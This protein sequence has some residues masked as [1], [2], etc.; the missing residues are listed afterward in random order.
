MIHYSLTYAAYD[1]HEIGTGSF[2][3]HLPIALTIKKNKS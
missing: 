3:A 1:Q 2:L